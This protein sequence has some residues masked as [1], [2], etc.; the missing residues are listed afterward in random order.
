MSSVVPPRLGFG[1][2]GGRLAGIVVGEQVVGEGDG[3]E[4]EEIKA[5]RA[6]FERAGQPGKQQQGGDEGGFQLAVDAQG[7]DAL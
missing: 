7:D 1:G 3:K 4:R 2:G 5:G 6:L